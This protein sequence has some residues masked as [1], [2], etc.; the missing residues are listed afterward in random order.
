[1]ALN[2]PPFRTVGIVGLGLIGGSIALRA[3]ATWRG[4][5]LLG[6]DRDGVIA[7][8]VS[9]QVV[10]Q[11]RASVADLADAD[12]VVLAVPVPDVIALVDA[13]ARAALPGLVTDVG[14]TKRDILHAA[15]AAQLQNFIGGHPMAGAERGG[16]T[17]ARADL[18]ESRPWLLVDAAEESA[19]VRRLQRFVV[20]LG[21]RPLH[22]DAVTHDR[23]MAYLS[24]LPQLLAV[25]LMQTAE[26]ACG[27]EMLAASGRAFR[28]MTRLASSPAHLWKG[29][30][31]TNADFVAEAARELVARLPASRDRVADAA[32][33]DELFAGANDG[34]ARLDAQP[35]SDQ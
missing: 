2:A 29:I 7:S 1:L 20:G 34:R 25:T 13:V 23:T 24:H 26:E 35:A 17:A 11:A 4:V 31:A 27:P 19:P 12:L 32:V 22:V 3:R 8:A 21:A 16:L 18:F 28:D 5:K 30:L 14:S 10:D 9:R 6:V 33:I 15:G